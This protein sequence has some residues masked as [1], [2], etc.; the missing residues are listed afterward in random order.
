MI[1]V[2][3]TAVVA[4]DLRSVDG[5]LVITGLDGAPVLA[6]PLAALPDP[7]Q[8]LHAFRTFPGAPSRGVV[9]HTIGADGTIT[10]H[11]ELPRRWGPVGST[12]QGLFA[13]GAWYPQLLDE[14]GVPIVDWTVTVEL[15]DGVT[16]TVGRSAGVGTLTWTGRS[17]RVALAAVRRGRLT[18]VEGG[19]RRVTVLSKGRP[20]G[21]VVKEV[22]RLSDLVP[23]PLDGVVVEAP[24][25]RRLWTASSDVVFLSDRAFRLT[26]GLE[27][28]HRSS[29]AKGLA[30]GLLGEEDPFERELAG[31]V[32]GE[33]V[34]DELT[35]LDT[36]RLLDVFSW[37]PMVNSMLARQRIA[38]YSDILDRAWPADPV[39]EDLSEVFD[40]HVP[41]TA[42]AAAIADRYGEPPL[43]E[44]GLALAEGQP[45]ADAL[46]EGG[47]PADLLD[48]FREP[49]LPQDYVLEVRDDAVV[50]E[51][52]VDA[53][54]PSEIVT[55]VVDGE[56]ATVDA[57]PGVTTVPLAQ[58]ARSVVLDPDLHLSQTSRVRDAWPARYDVTAAGWIT[59]AD[60][61][62]GRVYLGGQTT[63]RRAWDTRTLAIG[64]AYNSLSDLVGVRLGYIRRAGP[65]ID[66]LVRPHRLQVGLGA[67]V[68]NEGFADT[69]GLA[70]ALDLGLSWVWDTRVSWDFPLRGQRL[71]VLVGAG[72]I[73]QTEETWTS[74]SAQAVGIVSPHPRW[75][76][77]GRT[78]AAI[79]RSP[80]PH[81]LLVL[82]GDQAMRSIPSLPACP[83]ALYTPAPC[84][85]VATERALA[86]A[87]VRWAPIRGWSVPAVLA[88]GTEL[89][90]T[91]GVE[92]LV[93][94]VDGEPVAEAGLTAGLSAHADSFGIESSGIGITAGWP[95]AAYGLD[96]ERTPWPQ[97]YLRFGQ[98][99]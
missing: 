45:A 75:A 32:L 65:L 80:L 40:P 26:P 77:A 37:I 95:I 6:D 49:P 69:D 68:L 34:E 25:R 46:A 4:D 24:L 51:R 56:R 84:Q 29:V 61:S 48:R 64:S 22:G 96:L 41:G 87:E 62:Q 76:L 55:L 98:A 58:P 19:Q 5:T 15:P 70:V 33:I 1:G 36:D 43:R 23:V 88:W 99:F 74:A 52:R 31:A 72:G 47:L 53:A 66:G 27:F 3:I 17:D 54:A 35:L 59:G 11:A 2:E 86:T 60:L 71:A 44:L 28:A 91:G 12:G 97:L 7:T 79:A 81:R 8:D 39:K 90:L 57:P 10:F 63:V 50:L 85:P 94:R 73:P 78:T 21:R 93:A 16:G 82:G 20:R 42:A 83:D 30:T 67:A 89:Q 18:P 13:N 38:F 9:E 14:D 92:G